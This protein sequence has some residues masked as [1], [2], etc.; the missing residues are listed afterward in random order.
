MTPAE[1]ISA[2]AKLD[3]SVTSRRLTDWVAKGLL[4]PLQQ[5]G[6]GRHRGAIYFWSQ[7]DTLDQAATVCDLLSLKSRTEPALLALWLAGFRVDVGRVRRAWLTSLKKEQAN[8]DHFAKRSGGTEPAHSR[9]APTL[10]RMFA[11]K[12]GIDRDRLTDVYLEVLSVIFESDYEFESE[13]YEDDFQSVV[14]GLS[15]RASRKWGSLMKRICA[16]RH[17][18][19]R[20]S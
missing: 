4:P 1:L 20:R 15:A 16:L 10:A 19:R 6:R 8:L 11:E 3:Y 14:A 7:P 5:Q 17:Y 18:W 12:V 13:L 9:W 2:L